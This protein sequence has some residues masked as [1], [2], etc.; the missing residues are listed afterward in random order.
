M[1]KGIT[2]MSSTPESAPSVA[3]EQE[4]D[5]TPIDIVDTSEQQALTQ[6]AARALGAVA[7]RNEQLDAAMR[8]LDERA[9]FTGMPQDRYDALKDELERR[10]ANHR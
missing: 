3:L 5:V 1:T 7:A 10:F 8:Q 2:I 4:I 6:E 9:S